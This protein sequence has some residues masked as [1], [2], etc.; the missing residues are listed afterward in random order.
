MAEWGVGPSL[1]HPL[2]P[3][4]HRPAGAGGGHGHPQGR[5]GRGR[6]WREVREDGAPSVFKACLGLARTSTHSCSWGGFV[7]SKCLP[8]SCS[9]GACIPVIPITDEGSQEA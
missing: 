5:V 3:L 6:K 4:P 2:G 1:G 7:S 8:G 9:Q